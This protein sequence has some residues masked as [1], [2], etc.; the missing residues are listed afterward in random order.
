M[1]TPPNKNPLCSPQ[2]VQQNPTLAPHKPYFSTSPP[3][4]ILL[5]S[6]FQTHSWQL[7]HPQTSI[8]KHNIPILR[9]DNV[10][11]K[12]MFKWN[13]SSSPWNSPP[14]HLF[15]GGMNIWW[16]GCVGVGGLSPCCVP[17]VC[18]CICK[19]VYHKRTSWLQLL[20]SKLPFHTTDLKSNNS[21]S[22]LNGPSYIT[23]TCRQFD[24]MFISL[25]MAMMLI[26]TQICFSGV[27]GSN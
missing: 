3:L 7:P 16:R 23:L 26:A 10:H 2:L 11:S 20:P 12:N 24:S 14:T 15:P 13:T 21:G 17:M 22:R 18:I 27:H 8:G 9:K 1:E 25:I 5:P 19:M 6:W 4:P